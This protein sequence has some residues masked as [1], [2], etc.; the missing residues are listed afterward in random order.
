MTLIT[1]IWYHLPV[2]AELTRKLHKSKSCVGVSCRMQAGGLGD[3]LPHIR[4]PWWLLSCYEYDICLPIHIHIHVYNY[5]CC[6]SFTSPNW[7]EMM[8]SPSQLH[9]LHRWMAPVRRCMRWYLSFDILTFFGA[10]S[11]HLGSKI[12]MKHGNLCYIVWISSSYCMVDFYVFKTTCYVWS[13][14]YD[15]KRDLQRFTDI[16][17]SIHFVLDETWLSKQQW[18]WSHIA[19]L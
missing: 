12:E 9:G 4:T 10:T 1:N 14:V 5:A 16:P 17:S 3:P 2:Q 8:D 15:L 13:I 19:V 11:Q 6:I 7:I 18:Y